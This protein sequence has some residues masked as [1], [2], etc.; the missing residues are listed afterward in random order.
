MTKKIICVSPYSSVS[1]SS[2]IMIKHRLRRLLVV[3]NN[4]LVGIITHN[5]LPQQIKPQLLVKDIMTINPITVNE[6]DDI[7]SAIIVM[8]QINIGSLP[9]VNDFGH[10]VG[11]ITNYD[12]QQ[13]NNIEK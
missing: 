5:D 4:I 1:Y 12:I 2:Q 6:N 8:R 3:E 9:V 13:L 7:H 10:L 11:L